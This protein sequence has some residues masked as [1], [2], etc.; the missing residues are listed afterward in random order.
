MCGTAADLPRD[1]DFTHRP[2]A[3]RKQR[4]P[5]QQA[6]TDQAKAFILCQEARRRA[7]AS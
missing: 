4:G 5:T 6:L 7:K 1:M 2:D 3:V